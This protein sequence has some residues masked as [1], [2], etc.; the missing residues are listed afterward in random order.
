MYFQVK[1]ECTRSV[2]LYCFYVQTVDNNALAP[3]GESNI[4]LK[5]ETTNDLLLEMFITSPIAVF[6][7]QF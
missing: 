1:Y 3:G 2:C 5:T 6:N 4:K 7:Q